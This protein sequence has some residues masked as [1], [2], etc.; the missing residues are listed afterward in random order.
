M[1]KN[2]GYKTISIDKEKKYEECIPVDINYKLPF[3]NNE[4][5][6]IWCSEVIEHLINPTETISE[7]HRILKN[8]GEMII[9]TPNSGFWLYH[10]LRIFNYTPSDVQNKSHRHYFSI[11]DIRI[12][13]PNAI[14]LGYFP[15]MFIKFTIKRFIGL[16][17]PT[18]VIIQKNVT[19]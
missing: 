10:L 11:Q 4:F 14:I 19:E 8:N 6:L 12:L 7:F 9:T 16:L 17:S 1:L 5:D 2:L 13:F 3:K 15:Y 18:F